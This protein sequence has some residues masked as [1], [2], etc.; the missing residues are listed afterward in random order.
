[1]RTNNLFTGGELCVLHDSNWLVRQRIAGKVA[2]QAL[3]LLEQLVKEKTV[4]SLLELDKIAE[5][6]IVSHGCSATFLNYKGFPNSVCMSVDNDKTHA[7]VHGIPSDY[8]LQDGDLISFDLG[9][10]YEG[11]IGDTAITTIYG[12]PK[13]EKHVKL[14][15]D[16]KSAL[17]KAI[18]FIKLGR[19]QGNKDRIGCIGHTIYNFLSKKSY[20]VVSN[21]GGH[22]LSYNITHAPPFVSN[23]STI[24]SGIR[25]QTGMTLAIEPMAILNGSVKTWTGNDGW[26]VFTEYTSS[27]EEHTIFI[28]ENDVEI[29]TD[30]S[31]LC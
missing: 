21:Y 22:S 31:N 3:S 20:G 18:E 26:T 29:I 6:F 1:M 5:K 2:G 4:N 9:A 11:A 24:N 8:K 30:R 10:T 14:I 16:T 28:H 19:Q 13:S 25:L 17:A 7:L 15:S 27:H 12:D 23:K